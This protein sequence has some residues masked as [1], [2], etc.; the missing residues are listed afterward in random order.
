MLQLLSAPFA[1]WASFGIQL[2]Q[3]AKQLAAQTALTTSTPP[4]THAN[5]A[6]QSSVFAFNALEIWPLLLA[7]FVINI[8][9]LKLALPLAI[10]APTLL[11]SVWHAST[12]PTA[13][14]ASM[15]PLLFLETIPVIY[16]LPWL[17]IVSSA[18]VLQ[19]VLPVLMTHTFSTP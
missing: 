12:K 10:T 6:P 1:N 5:F 13:L 16:A 9:D 11:L 14:P 7:I 15:I 17:K 4:L 19:T 3:N 8:M 18:T 2:L